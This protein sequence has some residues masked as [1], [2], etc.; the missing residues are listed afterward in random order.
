LPE[1]SQAFLQYLASPEVRAKLATEGFGLTNREA[2]PDDML[3]QEAPDGEE[4]LSK[5][6]NVD[7]ETIS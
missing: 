1:K 2:K 4:A 5:L 6:V 3:A 7:W